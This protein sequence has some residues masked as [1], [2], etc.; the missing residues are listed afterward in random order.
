[1]ITIPNVLT[2]AELAWVRNL[3]KAGRH[4][5]G[6]ASALGLARAVKDNQQYGF[7]P[8]EAQALSDLTLSA[9]RRNAL[10]YRYALPLDV[11]APMINHYGAG[12]RYGW[13]YDS[14]LMQSAQGQEIRADLSATLFVSDPDDYDGGELCIDAGGVESRHKL[15]AGDML[16]YQAGQLHQVTPVTR[17]VRE[18]IVFWVQ[19]RVRDHE[20]R[21]LLFQ[22]DRSIGALAAKQPD[23]VEVRDL[24]GV[25]QNLARMWV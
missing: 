3:T 8:A 11:S 1:M 23:S 12:H 14:S 4:D 5:Q 20:R 15:A 6:Q 7:A 21:S 25:F 9:L 18:A 22:M 19:S 2:P 16:V 10:F 17:G 13:H 24:L